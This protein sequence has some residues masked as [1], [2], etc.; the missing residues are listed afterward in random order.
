[1]SVQEYSTP[2]TSGVLV[3]RGPKDW[4]DRLS[5]NSLSGRD[6]SKNS[7]VDSSGGLISVTIV[8]GRKGSGWSSE[9][10]PGRLYVGGT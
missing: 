2:L 4:L 8:V 10:R 6:T 7:N 3:G 9:R 5:T 1:M